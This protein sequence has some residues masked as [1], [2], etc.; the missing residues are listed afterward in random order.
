MP[1]SRLAWLD[2]MRGLLAF[3]VMVYHYTVWNSIKWPIDVGG[4]I[5]KSGPLA[6]SGFYI[7]SGYSIA[8]IYFQNRLS[9]SFLGSFAIKRFFRLAPLLWL[10]I[11]C[12][13]LMGCEIALDKL[14]LNMTLLF[15]FVAHDYY[16][17]TGSW[18]IGNEMV[19]YSI[20]PL[21]LIFRNFFAALLWCLSIFLV[22]LAFAI[23]SALV[24]IPASSSEAEHWSRYIHPANQ[25]WLFVAGVLLCL[26]RN[27]RTPPKKIHFF[28]GLI[29]L[30]SLA[31]Y[32]VSDN[33]LYEGWSR[34]I[35]CVFLVALV[36]VC[37]LIK[38]IP[39]MWIDRPLH[40]LGVWSYSVYL[41]H[42][43]AN[44]FVQKWNQHHLHSSPAIV[45]IFLAI[46]LTLIMSS[47]AYQF[48]EK[49]GISL[50]KHI[51]SKKLQYKN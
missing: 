28:V 39:P 50:A 45:S 13:Y 4:L 10:V 33:F 11:F 32:P 8:Y 17:T 29:A 2:Y 7:I 51:C 37:G 16:I 6:V 24:W 19:F 42:P 1:H 47:I 44:H 12:F 23:W 22:S 49:N 40:C 35:L 41:L 46:P 30:F 20:F 27:L 48:I 43:V 34:I 18:S 3:A 14:F 38:F 25:F 9:F 21:M 5:N 15:G 26:F 31:I 36:W